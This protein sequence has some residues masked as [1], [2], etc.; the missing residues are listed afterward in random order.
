[1]TTIRLG[2]MALAL[3]ALA[4]ALPVQQQPAK[5]QERMERAQQ[6]LQEAKE[7]LKLTPEQE[8]QMKPIVMEEI[9]QLKAV[10]DKYAGDPN[11]RS[12]MKMAREMRGIQS[13]TEGKIGKILSK[14]QMAEWKK[15]REEWRAQARERMGQ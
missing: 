2:L 9:R 8:E 4:P 6:R 5:K 10:R 11:R 14:E 12:R 13:D 7:R 15:M 3:A 1:M